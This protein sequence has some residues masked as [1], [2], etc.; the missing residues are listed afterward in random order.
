MAILTINNVDMLAP[1]V[2]RTPSFD[3]DSAA[4]RRNEEGYMQRD[5]I[6]QGINKI[7]VEWWG[8]TST[9]LSTIKSAIEP[10][11]VS[12]TFLTETGAI[13]KTMYAGDRNQELVKYQDGEAR[14]NFAFNLIEV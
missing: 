10:A 6:R 2:F 13:T 5:R 4:T 11:T 9:Q 1:S 12:V 7:E 3:L 8:I 14:W